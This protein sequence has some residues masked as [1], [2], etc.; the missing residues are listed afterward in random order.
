MFCCA[1]RSREADL[2][3]SAE[4]VVAVRQPIP[5]AF[6]GALVVGVG[7]PGQALPSRQ[8]GASRAV[9]DAVL[10]AVR[11]GEVVRAVVVGIEDWAP[12]EHAACH[13]TG[14]AGHG[15]RAVLVR[16]VAARPAPDAKV[17]IDD[18]SRAWSRE[19]DEKGW[20]IA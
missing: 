6:V 11:E 17:P 8:H 3:A 5:T 1:A 19:N 15:D 18:R 16:P 12:A 4:I 20:E 10:A 7:M 13:T 9:G 2:P 14:A